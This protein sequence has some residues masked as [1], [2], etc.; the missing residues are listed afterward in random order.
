MNNGTICNNTAE[1]TVCVAYGT[2][3]MN[4]GTIGKNKTGK[5]EVYL[6][7]TKTTA[8]TWT[9]VSPTKW[10]V[11]FRMNGGKILS[12]AV[13]PDCSV[14]AE[15]GTGGRT[16]AEFYGGEAGGNFSIADKSL[17]VVYGGRFTLFNVE[18]YLAPGRICTP[19]PGGGYSVY[20]GQV[21]T[22][23]AYAI[24]PSGSIV[25]DGQPLIAGEDFV[26]ENVPVGVTVTYSYTDANN[27][28]IRG[29]GLPRLAGTYD[30]AASF[31][32]FYDENG[33]Y[34]Q[35]IEK[36]FRLTIGRA[37][38][39]DGTLEKD[40]TAVYDG[41]PHTFRV[42]VAGF[43]NGETV[44][45]ARDLKIEYS[46]DGVTWSSAPYTATELADSRTVYYKVTSADY[47]DLKGE[48]LMR[49]DPK[50]DVSG[51]FPVIEGGSAEDV[52]LHY[53]GKTAAGSVYDSDAL[54]SEPGDYQVHIRAPFAEY[55]VSF[56]V[57]QPSNIIAVVIGVAVGAVLLIVC[58]VVLV[59]A[60]KKR[61]KNKAT[62]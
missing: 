1:N 39:S 12:D 3:T 24:L 45:T 33:L 13:V 57:P 60:V 6:S 4:G 28:A 29:S 49:I 14:F 16:R 20:N 59:I 47:N 50:I 44:D 38:L 15:K 40:N 56:S 8:S 7:S 55:D 51:K 34:Y 43:V 31:G 5:A 17:L 9:P 25:Y 35:P 21:G 61:K 10:Q 53:T 30:I 36:T 19:I 26:L 42:T 18:N 41:N 2:F 22:S 23:T 54:P 52:S 62:K 11:N 27:A 46:T 58:L 48:R 37:S 32:E